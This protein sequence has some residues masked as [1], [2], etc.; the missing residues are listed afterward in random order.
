MFLRAAYPPAAGLVR[1]LH[2]QGSNTIL[3]RRP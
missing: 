3:E 1:K 2:Y